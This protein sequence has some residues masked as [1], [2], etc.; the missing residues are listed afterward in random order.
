MDKKRVFGLSGKKKDIKNLSVIMRMDTHV[1]ILI[2]TKMDRKNLKSTSE[3]KLHGV[4]I[5]MKT[6]RKNLKNI[7][8]MEN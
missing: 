5:G 7:I 8:K 1:V 6:G 2:G 3:M 4:S